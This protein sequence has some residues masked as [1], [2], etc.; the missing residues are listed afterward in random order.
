MGNDW[1]PF[2]NLRV[3]KKMVQDHPSDWDQYIR[4]TVF[5]L[6]TKIQ[7]TTKYTPYY[8]MYGREARYPSE[9][10]IKWQV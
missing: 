6:R 2:F 8:L 10:P 7:L 4:S 3:F 5:G 9:I 1:F